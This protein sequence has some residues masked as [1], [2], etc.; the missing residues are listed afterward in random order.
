MCDGAEPTPGL[1][2]LLSTVLPGYHSPL[3]K[4]LPSFFP[5]SLNLLSTRITFCVLVKI[6]TV[7]K[8]CKLLE[9]S[10]TVCEPE[11]GHPRCDGTSSYVFR[12]AR[13]V[14]VMMQRTVG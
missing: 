9:T 5:P 13:T 11:T 12:V 7:N 2:R 10:L 4:L 14:R 1:P 6:E 3:K 8:I